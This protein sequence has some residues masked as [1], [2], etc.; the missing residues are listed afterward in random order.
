MPNR[1][2]KTVSFTPEQAA[3]VASAQ[4][5]LSATQR[6]YLDYGYYPNAA[7]SNLEPGMEDYINAQYWVGGTPIGGYWDSATNAWGVT[8]SLGVFFPNPGPS[9]TPQYMQE[10][11]ERI[12][13]GDLSTGQFRQFSMT[14][15]FFI[16]AN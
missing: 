4:T 7:P 9:Q 10:I 1:Q 8:A 15:Y 2:T 16:V 5:F 6:F 12:D 13:D 14:H 3:F 11:D